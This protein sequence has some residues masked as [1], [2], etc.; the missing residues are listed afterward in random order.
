MLD[1]ECPPLWHFVGDKINRRYQISKESCHLY[2]SSTHP[3]WDIQ[4][5]WNCAHVTECKNWSTNHSITNMFCEGIPKSLSFHVDLPFLKEVLWFSFDGGTVSEDRNMGDRW[6]I[7]TYCWWFRNPANHL[8][9][10]NPC[11]WWDKRI[12]YLSATNR[13]ITYWSFYCLDSAFDGG[14]SWPSWRIFEF[15]F[16]DFLS[17]P[18]IT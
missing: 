17:Q 3:F 1:I 6:P 11:K 2:L 12:N 9:S 14:F 10:I 4:D 16:S 15:A 8:G 13:I 5:Y 18:N 7:I